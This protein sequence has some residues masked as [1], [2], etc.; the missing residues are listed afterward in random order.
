[1]HP[2]RR[3]SRVAEPS[4]KLLERYPVK[5][6]KRV[7]TSFSHPSCDRRLSHLPLSQGH[8][9]SAGYGIEGHAGEVETVFIIYR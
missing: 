3:D 4:H 9:G 8:G 1:M 5:V 6:G 2:V 7:D